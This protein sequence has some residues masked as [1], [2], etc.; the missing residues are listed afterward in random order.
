MRLNKEQNAKYMNYIL[1]CIN[2]EEYGKENLTD[3]EKVQFVID[4]FVAEKWNWQKKQKISLQ[5][6]FT[7]YLQGL[8]TCLTLAFY[9]SDIVK[10]AE[11]I[12]GEKYTDKQADKIFG[13]Y[14]IFM[15]SK[16]FRLAKSLKINIWEQTA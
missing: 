7:E 12:S 1:S 13:N 11:E 16:F 2:A 8:P 15:A 4:C 3:K 9:N 6:A 5:S 10:L 14:W